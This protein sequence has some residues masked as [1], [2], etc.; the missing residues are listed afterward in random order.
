MTTVEPAPRVPAASG[1]GAARYEAAIDPDSNSTHARVLRLVGEGTRVLELGCA[2]GYMARALTARG[3]QVVGVEID[4][5]AAEAARAHCERVIVGDLDRLDLQAEL[6][7]DSFDVVVAA[8]VLEHLKDPVAVLG[9]VRP[10]LRPGGSVVASLP[11]VAHGSVRLALLTGRF[12]YRPKGLL[13]ATHLRFFTL[14]T[15]EALFGAA[16]FAIGHLE[17]VLVEVEAA[18]VAFDAAALPPG[19]LEALRGDFEARTYQFVVR[20]LPLPIPGLDYVQRQLAHLAEQHERATREL[21]EAQPLLQEL[22]VLRATVQE[23]EQG[24]AYLRAELAWRDEAIAEHKRGHAFLEGEV[25]NFKGI[26]AVREAEI[27]R[28][29]AELAERDRALA[30]RQ[31]ELAALETGELAAL[32]ARAA[33]LER[34]AE[35]ANAQAA[36]LEV[37]LTEREAEVRRLEAEAR[38][39]ARRLAER[40]AELARI[41]GSTVWRLFGGGRSA[42]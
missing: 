13:D 27:A 34:V 28:L 29:T 2:T 24:I 26:A 12:E 33:E 7:G 30:A 23:H 40:E 15:L 8:D 16:D 5:E 36:A 31:A 3:C 32:Q 10:L 38:E 21:A 20:A 6:A 25:A 19:V 39:Q 42:P 14:A 35:A 17:R 22:E 41:Q 9:A 11:N 18:E 37:A 1:S 4:A